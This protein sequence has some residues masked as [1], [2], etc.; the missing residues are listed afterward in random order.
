ME[1]H[2]AYIGIGSNIGDRFNHL[3]EALHRL[4]ALEEITVSAASRIYETEPVGE[5]EQNRF[6][7]GVILVS[8]T[9]EPEE[10]RL[11]CKTIEQELGRPEIYRRWS[12]RVIDLDLLLYDDSTISTETLSIPHPELHRRKFVLVPLLDTGNPMHPVMKKKASELLA[13]CPDPSV[14]IRIQKQLNIK[15]GRP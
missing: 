1:Q 6:Y 14:P 9:L 7:N 10:L 2:T 5:E 15:K 4:S 11:R 13:S 3:Q 12:P 8:T